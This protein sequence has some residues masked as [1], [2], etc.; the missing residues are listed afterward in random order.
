MGLKI[1]SDGLFLVMSYGLEHCLRFW[2][3]WYSISNFYIF[4]ANKKLENIKAKQ[5]LKDINQSNVS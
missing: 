3:A 5:E 1:F 2:H 4:K